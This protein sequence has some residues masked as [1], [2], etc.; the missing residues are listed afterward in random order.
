VLGPAE[1]EEMRLALAEQERLD[2][3][4]DQLISALE[5][6]AT[7]HEDRYS[8]PIERRASIRALQAVVKRIEGK[9][10]DA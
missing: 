3:N 8:G 4:A 10:L 2:A 7:C 6:V 9:M 1:F 5:W